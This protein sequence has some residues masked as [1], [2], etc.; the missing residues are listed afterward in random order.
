MHEFFCMCVISINLGRVDRGALAVPRRMA[1]QLYQQVTGREVPL[2]EWYEWTVIEM[3]R[4]ALRMEDLDAHSSHAEALED[5]K[6][7]LEELRD[8][9]DSATELGEALAGGNSGLRSS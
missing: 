6:E 8:S 9:R 7:M 5:G 3:E 2:H 1:E 4:L